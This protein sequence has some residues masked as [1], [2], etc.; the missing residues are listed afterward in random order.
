[1]G[2]I[3]SDVLA[4]ELADGPLGRLG[5]VGCAD[6]LAVLGD[7]I[8]ALER[9]HDDGAARHEGAELVEEA[10]P[11]VLR[12]EALGLGAGEVDALHRLDHEALLLEAPQDRARLVSLDRVGLDDRKRSFQCHDAGFLGEIVPFCNAVVQRRTDG[13]ARPA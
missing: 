6:H 11:L 7:G 12:V 8:V 4:V 9:H 13:A 1:V 2:R 3:L 10:P 5:R